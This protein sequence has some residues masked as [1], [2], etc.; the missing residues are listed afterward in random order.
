[1]VYARGGAP[2]RAYTTHERQAL[3]ASEGQGFSSSSTGCTRLIWD[4]IQA[5]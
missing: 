2:P 3:N 4:S 5:L 1:V